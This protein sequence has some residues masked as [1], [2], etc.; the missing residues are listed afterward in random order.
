VVFGA[1]LGS[2]ARAAVD[3]VNVGPMAGYTWIGDNVRSVRG[4]WTVPT[5]T[6]GDPPAYAA[7]W[8]GAQAAGS[9]TPPFIQIGV[10]ETLGLK[11]ARGRLVTPHRYVAFWADT[12]GHFLPRRLFAVRAGDRIS[13]LLALRR[14]RWLLAI[15][16]LTRHRSARFTTRQEARGRF[17]QGEWLQEHNL[18]SD[19]APQ[20]LDYPRLGPIRWHDLAVN[21]RAPA[22]ADLYSRWLFANGRYFAPTPLRDNGFVVV[23]T[24]LTDAGHQYLRIVGDERPDVAFERVAAAWTRRTPHRTI[25]RE[26]RADA[27]FLT[28]MADRLA[29]MATPPA[30]RAAA[31]IH[32]SA[33]RT[34]IAQVRA[35]TRITPAGLQRWRRRWVQD[36]DAAARAT[37]TLRRALNV[38][39]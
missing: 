17:S 39:D 13:A 28:R 31:T 33:L 8:I 20:E 9:T 36:G 15:R 18:H 25:A 2:T 12:D 4:A 22:Y 6:G 11:V 1:G 30:A 16:D 14:G 29:R 5:I 26:S 38:P 19:V 10:T 3:D 35:A 37:H 23:P 7:T 34:L 24:T 27:N 21:G 32:L